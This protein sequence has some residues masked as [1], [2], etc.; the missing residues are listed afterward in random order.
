MCGGSSGGLADALATCELY[1]EST[2]AWTSGPS[3]A[4]P[5]YAASGVAANGRTARGLVRD[6]VTVDRAPRPR[7]YNCRGRLRVGWRPSQRRLRWF[8][9]HGTR[10][11]IPAA[12]RQR[13][14]VADWRRHARAGIWHGCGSPRRCHLRVR[15]P[16]RKLAGHE[17]VPGVRCDQQHMGA[18]AAIAHCHILPCGRLCKR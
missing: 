15:R 17:R 18:G 8:H 16:R 9:R 11:T 2:G 5:R 13:H 6:R 14:R 4:T 10:R 1:T 12:L 7:V 3:L